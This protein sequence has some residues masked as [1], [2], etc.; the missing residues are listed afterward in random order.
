MQTEYIQSTYET[1]TISTLAVGAFPERWV[2]LHMI[3]ILSILPFQQTSNAS[4]TP[5]QESCSCWPLS[6]LNI[7]DPY[8]CFWSLTFG[9]GRSQPQKLA[10]M[11]RDGEWLLQ[12][13]TASTE[14]LIADMAW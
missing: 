2:C 5:G 4:E 13:C 3:G 10:Q 11:P 14:V 1:L 7:H 6:I 9:I 12:R 8:C